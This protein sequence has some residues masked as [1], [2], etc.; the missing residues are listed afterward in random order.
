MGGLKEEIGINTAKK[1]LCVALPP[2]IAEHIEAEAKRTLS[3]KA[4]V[5][6][7]YLSDHIRDCSNG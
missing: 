4:Q 5:T 7:K 2:D 6:R 1:V 3:S